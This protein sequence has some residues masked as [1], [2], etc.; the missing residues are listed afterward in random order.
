MNDEM[1]FRDI[2]GI[3]VRELF[4][5]IAWQPAT[6]LP[7]LRRAVCFLREK[8]ESHSD[9][10]NWETPIATYHE[11]ITGDTD[12][13]HQLAPKATTDDLRQSAIIRKKIE[14]RFK[15][16]GN[17]ISLFRFSRLCDTYWIG[18]PARYH[19]MLEAMDRAKEKQYG[20]FEHKNWT[21]RIRYF[22]RSI[23]VIREHEGKDPI[24]GIF[25]QFQPVELYVDG[26][27]FLGFSFPIT[28]GIAFFFSTREKMH[29]I[30]WNKIERCRLWENLLNSIDSAIHL[31]KIKGTT[32][33]TPASIQPR[34]AD[35]EDS[36]KKIFFESIAPL[37]SQILEMRESINASNTSRQPILISEGPLKRRGRPVDPN[38]VK[39]NEIVKQHIK[40][41]ADFKNPEKVRALFQALDDKDIPLS[42]M[43]GPPGLWEPK[44]WINL[45]EKPRSKQYQHRIEVL[46]RS[47]FK[48]LKKQRSAK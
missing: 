2:F 44:S 18:I 16:N 42:Q 32:C 23:F 22:A 33:I 25:F 29:P 19:R 21:E 40:R 9:T 26:R 34:H 36:I 14:K 39:R 35:T 28:I 48:R 43:Q 30:S 31:A 15:L 47:L 46:K 11:A 37:T 8:L 17:A 10:V 24:G 20:L 13:K 7:V 1:I 6:F 3:N 41:L 27:L 38:I 4:N 5:S 45:V 12:I